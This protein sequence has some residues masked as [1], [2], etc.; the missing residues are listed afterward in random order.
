MRWTVRVM[1]A[2][3]L[4]G[5]VAAQAPGTVFVGGFGQYTYFDSKWNL[6][7]GLANS[8][9]WGLRVGAFIAQGVLIRGAS[10]VDEVSD[11][12]VTSQAI[13]SAYELPEVPDRATILRIAEPWRPYRGWA[14]VLLHMWLRREGGP[15]FKRPGRQGKPMLKRAGRA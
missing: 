2:L 13:Q 1:T 10:L 4:A 11:D 7:T 12:E 15:A 6:D 14:T 5:P 8:W 9:G 3:F